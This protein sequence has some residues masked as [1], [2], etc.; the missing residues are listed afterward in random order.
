MRLPKGKRLV[1]TFVMSALLAAASTATATQETPAQ[2]AAEEAMVMGLGFLESSDLDRALAVFEE[3]VMQAPEWSQAHF[4]HGIVLLRLRRLQDALGPLEAATRLDPRSV[5]AWSQLGVARRHSGD[6]AGAIKALDH[7]LRRVA[8]DDRSR[9]ASI[10]HERGVAL[11]V[12]REPELAVEAFATAVSM[13]PEE[14]IYLQALGGA[15]Q[16]AGDIAGAKEAMWRA[17]QVAPEHPRAHRA[18]GLLFYEQGSPGDALPFFERAAELAPEWGNAFYRVGLAHRALGQLA[19]AQVALERA[20]ELNYD[21]AA[22][23][24]HLA[25]VLHQVG[26]IDAAVEHLEVAVG[27]DPDF[28]EAAVALG[29]ALLDRGDTGRAVEALERGTEALPERA[30]AWVALGQ[31]L[32]QLGESERAIAGFRRAIEAEPEHR[33]ALFALGEALRRNGDLE[34]AQPY[35]ERHAEL[36]S[37]YLRRSEGRARAQVLLEQAKEA[38]AQKRIAEAGAALQAAFGSDPTSLEVKVLLAALPIDEYDPEAAISPLRQIAAEHPEDGLSRSHLARALIGAGR[39]AEGVE[40]LREILLLEPNNLFVRLMLGGL[41]V[42]LE[43]PRE[44][45]LVIKAGVAFTPDQ[46]QLYS[47][48]ALAY[49][50]AGDTQAAAIARRRFL[51]LVER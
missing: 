12:M 14:R 6:A 42:N 28:G 17:I 46:P 16:R 49:D 26:E 27:S 2:W 50:A 4:Y 34:A 24:Y 1:P 23:R 33:G 39:S 3:L 21:T 48:L 10:W 29:Q 44:A 37:A 30:D 32:L 51:A 36:N 5:E 18:L 8:A 19:A 22:V 45:V 35:L 41:L 47:F 13:A 11:T 9:A 15:R 38:L 20:L 43:K 25:A 40:P 7:A 31:A